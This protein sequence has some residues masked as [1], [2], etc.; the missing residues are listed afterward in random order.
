MKKNKNFRKKY[1]FFDID[2][3]IAIGMPR[4]IPDSTRD[5]LNKLKE[6]G[7]FISV[8]TGRMYTMTK[9]FCDQ[10]GITNM[11]T[12]GGFGTVL[13]G[14]VDIKPLDKQMMIDIVDVFEE[15]G[16]PWAIC[17]ADE[18]VW[19]TRTK[20]FYDIMKKETKNYMDTVIDPDLDIRK[21][22]EV[23]KGFACIDKDAETNLEEL[24]NVTYTRYQP[25]YIII[26]PDDKS[27]GI[28]KVM[29][30]MGIEDQDVVV[31]GDNTNDIKMFRSEWTSIAMGNAVEE[32][33]E[34]ADFVTK[35]ADDGGIEYACRHFGWID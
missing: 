25:S 21:V 14:E 20:K 1:F 27:L 7:H 24:K 15:K 34:I 33:K 28:R 35:D 17:L 19:H 13:E 3:T 29:N 8:A 18:R 4:Y 32:L 31:F 22:K 9:P 6:K 2:G 23:Y 26:E 12:D 5:T 30:L 10:F 16:I 11:V